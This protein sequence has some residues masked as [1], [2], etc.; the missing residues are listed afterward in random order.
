MHHSYLQPECVDEDVWLHLQYDPVLALGAATLPEAGSSVSQSVGP[1]LPG[2]DAQ[3]FD[4]EVPVVDDTRGTPGRPG[5]GCGTVGFT[6]EFGAL[7]QMTV[8]GFLGS[9]RG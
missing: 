4:A 2:R 7:Y 5:S 9:F 3:A 6:F 8:N 1:T